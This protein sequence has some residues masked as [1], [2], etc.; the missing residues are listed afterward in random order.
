MLLDVEICPVTLILQHNG[1]YSI[2]K[3]KNVHN[4][5][6]TCNL[7]RNVA[8]NRMPVHFSYELQPNFRGDISY[9]GC[10]MR[11]FVCNLSHNGIVVQFAGKFAFCNRTFLKYELIC[12]EIG[13]SEIAKK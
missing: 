2:A 1:E 12:L 5:C 9:K 10:Y 8:K 6:Y 7:Y 3:K 4:T 13:N 11:N